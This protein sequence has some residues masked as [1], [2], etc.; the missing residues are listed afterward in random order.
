MSPNDINDK[1]FIDIGF[2]ITQNFILEH[3]TSG[4]YHQA[5][6]KILPQLQANIFT[7]KFQNIPLWKI[8]QNLSASGAGIIEPLMKEFGS[9]LILRQAFGV[10]SE[11][12][13]SFG[14]AFDI[15]VQGFEND[16]APIAKDLQKLMAKA[17]SLTLNYGVSSF[18]HVDVS[19]VKLASNFTSTNIEIPSITTVDLIDGE[20]IQGISSMRSTG[21]QNVLSGGGTNELGQILDAFGN[22]VTDALGNAMTAI[23]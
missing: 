13:H 4:A 14:A 3:F 2:P 7:K 5:M 8:V 21:F 10:T 18:M 17:S 23:L 9:S 6:G 20:I 1:T 22:V 15:S 11:L 16:L 19:L 12:T